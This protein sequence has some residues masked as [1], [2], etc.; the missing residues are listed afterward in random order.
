MPNCPT[1]KPALNPF[2]F[3]SQRHCAVSA[4][5]LPVQHDTVRV[6]PTS[7]R[8]FGRVVGG[9]EVG[10]FSSP[11]AVCPQPSGAVN[12]QINVEY[13]EGCQR[14]H[15]AWLPIPITPAFR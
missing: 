15:A 14:A 2:G 4:G 9:D 5:L 1:L 8:G 12:V 10:A 7:S 3:Y 6:T 11:R 13:L